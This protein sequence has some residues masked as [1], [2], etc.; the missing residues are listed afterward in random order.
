[1]DDH[2][3]SEAGPGL[4]PGPSMDPDDPALVLKLVEEMKSH[5]FF[6]E[7]RRECLADIETSSVKHLWPLLETFY[8]R[9]LRL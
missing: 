2:G 4:E 9:N 3:A 1:M 7:I 5:G 8:D 6:D